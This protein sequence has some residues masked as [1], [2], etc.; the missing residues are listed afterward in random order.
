MRERVPPNFIRAYNGAVRLAL[1]VIAFAV[2]AQIPEQ[3]ARV[4]EIEARFKAGTPPD[5]AWAARLAADYQQRQF[6]PLVIELLNHSDPRV[7][8]TAWDAL[9]TL[10][11]NV[12]D[13]ILE[14]AIRNTNNDAALIL[15]ALNSPELSARLL[16]ENRLDNKT[17]LVLTGSLFP[18]RNGARLLRQWK[19]PMTVIIADKG[20]AL[21]PLDLPMKGFCADGFDMNSLYP[22]YR[23]PRISHAMREETLLTS[24]PHPLTYSSIGISHCSRPVSNVSREEYTLDFL[25]ALANFEEAPPRPVIRYTSAAQYRTAAYAALVSLRNYYNR[26][27]AAL[28]K[29]GAISA[30]DRTIPPL[31]VTV[32][33]QRDNRLPALPEIRWQLPATK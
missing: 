25:R 18:K 29:S 5:L 24:G 1:F 15:A 3:S 32:E 19:M 16:D 33:D 27:H 2:L 31:N 13:R 11:T 26:L 12:P 6:V 21:W 20:R 22:P 8:D 7:K 14:P 28:V 4:A 10:R 30:D 23:F 17:W 9:V